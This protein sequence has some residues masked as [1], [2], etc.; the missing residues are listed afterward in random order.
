MEYYNN[1]KTKTK[2]TTSY[3]VCNNEK[4]FTENST[5]LLLKRSYDNAGI[6]QKNNTMLIIKENSNDIM[7]HTVNH[8]IAICFSAFIVK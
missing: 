3:I 2:K 1:F 7:C 4:K 5:R 8:V 6:C